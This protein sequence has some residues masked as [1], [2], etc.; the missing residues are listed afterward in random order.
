ME[1]EERRINELSSEIIG[2]AKPSLIVP[3]NKENYW[4]LT[5]LERVI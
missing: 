2:L 1:T 4:P 5:S 3:H